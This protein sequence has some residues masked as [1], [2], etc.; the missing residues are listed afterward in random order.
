M[1]NTANYFDNFSAVRKANEMV[2]RYTPIFEAIDNFRELGSFTV[3]AIGEHL[4]G[5]AYHQKHTVYMKWHR[6]PENV[7]TDEAMS[8]TAQI[9]AAVRKMVSSGAVVAREVKDIS[10]PYTI[11]V[12]GYYYCDQNG[13]AL[14]DV[15]IVTLP[16]GSECEVETKN[17][18]GVRRVKGT[19]TETKYST[20]TMYTFAD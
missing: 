3:R 16:D 2:R 15:T 13:K 8:M 12:E 20:Y 1:N 18:R 17:L 11:E 7:R 4:M 5:D 6:E 19:H 14:P 10:H 9:T